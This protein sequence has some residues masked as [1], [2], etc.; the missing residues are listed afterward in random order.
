MRTAKEITHPS[1]LALK[2]LIESD[3]EVY[4]LFITMFT[5]KIEPPQ[6]NP[7]SDY[8]DMLRKMQAIIIRAPVYK[9]EL[10]NAP[11]NHL[12]IY[13]LATPSGTMAFIN[14]KVNKCFKNILNSWAQLLNS[15][16][17]QEV[18]NK[19]VNRTG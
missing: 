7:I 9:S 8:M 12:L 6:K 4:M 16:D 15:P 14:D 19:K 18:L 3:P 5:Q 1:L 10:G 2:N 13:V 11:I 17:S